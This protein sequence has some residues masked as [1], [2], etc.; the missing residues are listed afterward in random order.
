MR[1]GNPNTAGR[2]QA[3]LLWR[4]PRTG[5][6]TGFGPSS[7]ARYHQK[8]GLWFSGAACG[9]GS[10]DWS[11]RH[12]SARRRSMRFSD[13]LLK[14]TVA[15]VLAV[16]CIVSPGLADE[17]KGATVVLQLPASMPPDAVRALLAD[18][19]AKGAR[20]PLTRAADPPSA[21]PTP[22]AGLAANV[23][24]GTAKALR[25]LPLLGAAPQ[26]WTISLRPRVSRATPQSDFGSLH[27]P[28]W[29]RRR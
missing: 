3:R 14:P 29:R 13:C 12:L 2:W 20:S 5:R 6:F 19:A 7:P 8:A 11:S 28:V 9:E 15:L 26:R 1:L 18:L 27:S 4:R 23:W 10:R 22:T 17:P 25:S 16:L 24:K 21:A